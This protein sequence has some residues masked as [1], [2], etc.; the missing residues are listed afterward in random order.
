MKSKKELINNL[1][2]EEKEVA[3]AHFKKIYLYPRSALVQPDVTYKKPELTNHQTN[4]L[5]LAWLWANGHVVID[6]SGAWFDD[7]KTDVNMEDYEVTFEGESGGINLE[8]FYEFYELDSLA[9]K[10]NLKE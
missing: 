7:S 2:K 6:D 9:Q 5:Y 1:T 8:L 4:I 10:L 3:L